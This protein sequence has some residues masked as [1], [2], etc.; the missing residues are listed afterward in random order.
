[1]KQPERLPQVEYRNTASRVVSPGGI[2]LI[3]LAAYLAFVGAKLAGWWVL[4]P[5]AVGLAAGA[6]R[7]AFLS[8]RSTRSV[9]NLNADTEGPTPASVPPFKERIGP[10]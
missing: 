5:L 9:L 10:R 4:A 1:M 7:V 6:V 2:P 3:L 8:R